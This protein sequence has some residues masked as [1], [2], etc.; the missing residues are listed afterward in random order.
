MSGGALAGRRVLAT[1]AGS[2]IGL[3]TVAAAVAAGASVAGTVRDE[4]ERAALAAHA[5]AAIPVPAPDLA[6]PGEAERA[7][8]AAAAALGGLDGVVSAAGIFELRGVEA[9]ERADW[10][11]MIAVNLTAGYA[12]AR[13]AV[14]HLRRARNGAIVFVSSQIGL[15]GHPSAAAYA[16]SKAGLNGLARALSLELAPAGIRVNAAAPGPAETPMTEAARADPERRARLLEAIPL[17]RFGD[18]AEIAAAILFL[19]SDAASFVTGQVLCVDG[20][21]T[22]R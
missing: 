20:G 7:V 15:V 13:A 11:R 5:P 4:R 17:G 8:A 10:E 18:A 22:A 1:G 9:T 19:L 6:R 3:A 2:G 21:Y 12:V 14:P 16:A